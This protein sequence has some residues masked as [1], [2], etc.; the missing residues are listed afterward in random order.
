MRNIVVLDEAARDIAGLD[1]ATVERRDDA[2]H[3][4]LDARDGELR[5]HH[6]AL[7]DDHDGHLCDEKWQKPQPKCRPGEFFDHDARLILADHH[8]T[9]QQSGA[10]REDSRCTER[11]PGREGKERGTRA[12]PASTRPEGDEEQV[13]E[14]ACE[15]K[16]GIR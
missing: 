7:R 11:E 10:K 4:G 5:G 15:I 6:L 9:E 1:G 12:R 2:D 14:R 8:E 3:V 13:R 16:R